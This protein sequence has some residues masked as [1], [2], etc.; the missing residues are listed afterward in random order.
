MRHS[1]RLPRAVVA[2]NQSQRSVKLDS[3]LTGVIKGADSR[4]NQKVIEQA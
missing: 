3:F 4:K 2:N 1:Y